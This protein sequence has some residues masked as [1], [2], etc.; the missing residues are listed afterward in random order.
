M[1]PRIYLAIDNCFAM[2]RWTTPYEWSSI[3]KDIGLSY[4]ECVADNEIDPLL[5]DKEYLKSWVEDVREAE[6][7]TG[8]KV[9]FLYSG[10]GTYDTTGL[11]HYDKRVRKHILDKW[12][13][14]FLAM[15]A[16]LG[17]G[18][19]YFV[20]GFPEYI[21][22]DKELYFQYTDIVKDYLV[23]VNKLAIELGCPQLAI[24]QMY[25]PHQTPFTIDKTKEFMAEIGRRSGMPLYFT[26]D[27]GHHN[28]KF[29]RPSIQQ[30]QAAYQRYLKDGYIEIWLGNKTAYSIFESAMPLNGKLKEADLQRIYADMDDNG[31]L[32]AEKRDSDCYEWLSDIGCYSPVIHLQQTDGTFSL[33]KPFTEEYN[34][35]GVIKPDKI[36]KALA[37]SYQKPQDK[38]LPKQCEDIYLTFEFYSGTS[39]INR[40]I[41]H[42]YSKSV[43]YWRKYVPE[44]GMKLSDIL[45]GI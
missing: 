25:T 8:T 10:N 20:H 2:K 26:E 27:V 22:Q 32:F 19:G 35:L 7:K 44:D 17:V 29:I 42:D 43:E 13:G 12:F 28:P 36:L 9:I 37:E 6:K 33:H 34:S 30:I 45:A 23:E 3:V 15:G 11:A 40:Q 16:E 4:V 21:L 39:A 14:G 38:D 1:D 18:V 41:I 5:M 24:E 31:H